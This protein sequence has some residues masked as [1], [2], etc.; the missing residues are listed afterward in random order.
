MTVETGQTVAVVEPGQTVSFVASFIVPENE[1]NLMFVY[2][3]GD[4][5]EINKVYKINP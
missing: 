3:E 2:V 5:G 4:V 1:T